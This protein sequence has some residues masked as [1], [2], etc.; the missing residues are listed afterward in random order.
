MGTK[1]VFV[2]IFQ[3]VRPVLVTVQVC[4]H[5]LFQLVHFVNLVRILNFVA[6]HL[7]Y[8]VLMV[9]L[10]DLLGGDNRAA[11]GAVV[12]HAGIPYALA[13]AWNA[14]RVLENVNSLGQLADAVENCL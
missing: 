12:G 7:A 10:A 11:V 9:H 5:H 3:H 14:A 4:Q 2:W 1:L 6:E 8:P 13:V